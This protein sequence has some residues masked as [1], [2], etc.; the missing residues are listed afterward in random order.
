LDA[1]VLVP[2]KRMDRAKSRLAQALAADARAEL[3]LDLLSGVLT[4]VRSAG[5]DRITLVT[6][7]N[8]S[9]DGIHVWNDDG[10]PWN[11]ALAAATNAVVETELLAVISADL[12]WLRSSEVRTLLEQTPARGIAVARAHDGGTNAVAMRPPGALATV[13]GRPASARLH[14]EAARA[15]RL[16]CRIIDVPGLAFDVDTPADLERMLAARAAAAEDAA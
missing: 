6:P 4:A 12:P 16:D 8:V 13:F 1:H 5:V 7:E 10:L 14:A 9:H 11:D 2:L 3:M 15:R